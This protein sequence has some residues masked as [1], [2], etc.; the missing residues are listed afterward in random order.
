MHGGNA[1]P[2]CVRS[3]WPVI[4]DQSALQMDTTNKASFVPPASLDRARN[5]ACWPKSKD[6]R[7]RFNQM[8]KW[9]CYALFIWKFSIGCDVPRTCIITT[10]LADLQIVSCDKL[11]LTGENTFVRRDERI[12]NWRLATMTIWCNASRTTMECQL[13]VYCLK[14]IATIR[15]S[16]CVVLHNVE[17]FFTNIKELTCGVSVSLW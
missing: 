15:Y 12:G 14:S 3:R 17:Y 9:T 10:Y 11:F 4:N 7:W 13:N 6:F 1:T 2:I 8:L 5:A 16:S